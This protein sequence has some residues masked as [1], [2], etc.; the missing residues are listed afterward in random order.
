[1][2]IWDSDL[3]FLSFV[4]DN[5]NFTSYQITLPDPFSN[6]HYFTSVITPSNIITY[7]NG[8]SYYNSSSIALRGSFDRIWLGRRIDQYWKGWIPNFTLYNRALTPAEIL[9]NYNA[10]KGRFR[11]T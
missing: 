5:T 1:M 8:I 10:T 3:G 7:V 2:Q 6:W 4:G 9:Q 11:L